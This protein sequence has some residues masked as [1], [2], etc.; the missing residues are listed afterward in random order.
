MPLN[1]LLEIIILL[2]GSL[3]TLSIPAPL[4]IFKRSLSGPYIFHPIV[5]ISE[6]EVT[7]IF[8]DSNRMYS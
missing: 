2:I 3:E 7:L 1:K 4:V 6:I 5:F 8:K